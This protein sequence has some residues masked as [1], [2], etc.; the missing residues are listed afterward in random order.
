MGSV[1][2]GGG[3]ACFD[4]SQN[5]DLLIG[6]PPA[7]PSAKVEGQPRVKLYLCIV[8]TYVTFKI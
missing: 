7:A 2:G 1:G 8:F 3:G 6:K 5:C 4:P